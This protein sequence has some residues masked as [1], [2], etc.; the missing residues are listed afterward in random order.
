[1]YCSAIQ[2][3]IMFAILYTYSVHGIH[4]KKKK[5]KVYFRE[6]IYIITRIL[7]TKMQ[8]PFPS[9]FD[10]VSKIAKLLLAI[11]LPK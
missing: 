10:L 4:R 1:M 9:V 2:D 6:I 3:T 5:L 11:I 8:N 7:E